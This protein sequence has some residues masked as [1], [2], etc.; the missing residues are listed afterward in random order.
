MERVI[1]KATPKLK[2][3]VHETKKLQGTPISGY[4]GK[5]E[6]IDKFLSNIK[7]KFNLHTPEDWH[8]ITREQIQS[9]G[10]NSILSNF[11]MYEL[12]CMACPEGKSI[13]NNLPVYWENKENVLSFLLE[14]K[15]KY[16][17]NSSKDWNS[18]THKHIKSNGGNSLL[19]KYSVYELKCMACPE[20]KSNF[21][22]SQPPGFWRNKE[23][24]HQFLLELKEKYNLN[25]PD[26]WNS[27]TSSHI[28]S[29]GGGYLLQKYSMYELKCM[30]CP[31]E[32][33]EF[34]TSPQRSGHWKNEENVLQ[35]LSEIK[36][37]YNLNTP[38]DWN[39]LSAAQI[40]ANRG[41]SLLHKYSMLELKTMACP[42]GKS[43]F[44]N[45]P[46]S[47]LNKIQ[48][49]SNL[50]QPKPRGYWENKDNILQFLS[51]IKEKY[52]L[53]TP[54]NW[55]S[56]TQ[57]HIKSIDG[58]STLVS[59]YSM[60]ELKCLACPEGK[61][62]FDNPKKYKPAKYWENE[63]NIRNFLLE[64]KEKHNLNTPE[65]WN[66]ITHKYIQSNGGST[67]T[68]KHSIYELKCMAC[69]EGK[70]IFNNPYQSPGYW[71]NKE[72]ILQFLSKIKEKYNLNTPEDWNSVTANQFQ[73]EGGSRLVSKYSIYELKCMACPEGKLIFNNPNQPPGY[74]E[75]SDNVD[76]FFERVKKKYNLNTLEDWKRISKNQI[77]S[78]GG[79]GLFKSKNYSNMKIKLES[80]N[81]KTGFIP[82][83]ELS[84]VETHKRASQ[85]WL[86]LQIRKLFP[87]EEIVE[88]YFHSE[89]SRIS[90]INV[91]FDIFM[92]R[93]NIAIEYHG[94]HH[95]ED[96]PSGFANLETYQ[97]R[98]LEK[99]KLCSEHGI[100]LIVI[101][102]WWDNKLDS[103]KSFLYSKINL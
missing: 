8:T 27:I 98:D 55:N 101:P 23:N 61:L 1:T 20:G 25:T 13:F 7:Q 71:D 41:S 39:L 96:I 9:N 44:N 59:K 24:I 49:E 45:S 21:K 58:G 70:S 10:G 68:S 4:W 36:E 73:S 22:N 3:S 80:P 97:N 76:K 54:E 79:W 72:N 74:W 82:F 103:L 83:S 52:N 29:N 42:E 99:E 17:L 5:R 66:S 6:N 16:N 51:E 90:G 43:I 12:K 35:F 89:I 11:S 46:R 77:T 63:E 34:K 88:D 91:Q 47:N 100:Q 53:N 81:G 48:T 15:E 65:D 92:I 75:N 60:F 31:E 56:I 86:F 28:K 37:K 57:T 50:K 95:Y 69:P 40:K 94:M 26:D 18:I 32:K 85:R 2:L 33:S 67:L 62:I 19:S 64:I 87:G 14:L 78:E 84:K 102:Y 38:E 93:R 30:A